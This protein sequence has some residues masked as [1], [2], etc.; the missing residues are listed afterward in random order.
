MKLARSCT[1]SNINGETHLENSSI[2]N[3]KINVPLE[4]FI[5]SYDKLIP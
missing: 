2:I 4:F 1:K 3:K 5:D